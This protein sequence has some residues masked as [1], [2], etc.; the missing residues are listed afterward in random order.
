MLTHYSE[1]AR[2]VKT[3]VAMS[4]DPA[5]KIKTFINVSRFVRRLN[6]FFISTKLVHLVHLIVLYL[7]YATITTIEEG[8]EI[9]RFFTI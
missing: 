9:E 3:E 1:L 4:I 2:I 7:P 5:T 6:I 8:Q